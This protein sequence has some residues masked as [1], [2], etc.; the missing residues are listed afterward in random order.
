M[1]SPSYTGT[2]DFDAKAGKPCQTWYQ[3]YGDLK[4]GAIPVVTIHGGPGST[5]DYLLSL[6]DLA[7]AHSIPVVFYDQLGNGNSTHLPEK[8]G[9]EG[10]FWTEQLFLDELDNLLQHLG[11]QDNYA[12]LGQSWGGMLAARHAAR[13]PKG[14]KRLVLSDSPASIPLFVKAAKDELLT[15]LPPD[16]QDTI[17]RSE[18]A[19]TTDS[20]EYKDAVQVFYK[21]YLCR[22]D[23]WPAELLRSFDWMEKDHTVYLTMNGPSEFHIIGSLKNWTIED[24]AHKINVPTLLLNGAYDEASDSTVKPL[25]KAIPKIKW[26]TFAESSHMPHWEEREKYMSLVS[27][28]LT[29]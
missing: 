11:I 14:L 17:I 10:T 24:E 22:L 4:S 29:A 8:S 21:R 20:Q 6:V 25:F 7:T 28:F 15:K 23:P 16:I 13:Q 2:V 12:I 9:D 18:E 26:Y 3:V 1:V 5:H 19:G 27:E